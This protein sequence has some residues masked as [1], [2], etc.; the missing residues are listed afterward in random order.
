MSFASKS[1]P[2]CRDDL[3]SRLQ[4]VVEE[5]EMDEEEEEERRKRRGGRRRRRRG[6]RRRGEWMYSDAFS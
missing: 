4:K 5:E 2:T 6:S 3:P 1:I